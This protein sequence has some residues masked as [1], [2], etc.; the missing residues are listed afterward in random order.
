LTG[1]LEAGRHFDA[2]FSVE[3]GRLA[4]FIFHEGQ[5]YVLSTALVRSDGISQVP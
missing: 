5:R 4:V 1:L 2:I 3:A